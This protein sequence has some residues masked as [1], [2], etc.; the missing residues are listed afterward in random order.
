MIEWTRG[1]VYT[2]GSSFVTF[3]SFCSFS[4]AKKNKN[5]FEITLNIRFV[6][7]ATRLYM[8]VHF[9]DLIDVLLMHCCKKGSL[10]GS[11]GVPT[12]CPVDG[13]PRV[14]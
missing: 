13:T 5:E 9:L 7:F 2:W 3:C 11:F 14:P 1:D 8:F 4:F 10:K 6:R 12:H